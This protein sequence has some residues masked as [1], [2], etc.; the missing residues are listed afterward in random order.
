MHEQSNLTQ[1]DTQTVLHLFAYN[2]IMFPKSSKM[3]E[4]SETDPLVLQTFRELVLQKKI[5]DRRGREI[6]ERDYG[7]G[8]MNE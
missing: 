3:N 4:E 7:F 1:L 8:S 5:F 6:F 2:F